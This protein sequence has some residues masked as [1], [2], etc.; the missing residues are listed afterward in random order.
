M[1]RNKKDMVLVS[2]RLDSDVKAWLDDEAKR[3]YR[4]LS[5]QLRMIIA[6]YVRSQQGPAWTP[7]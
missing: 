7:Q 5:D 4:S 3:G 6:E 2:V 1:G